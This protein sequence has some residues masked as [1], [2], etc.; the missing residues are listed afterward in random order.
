MVQ[1]DWLPSLL[2]LGSP[3]D[4]SSPS[5]LGVGNGYKAFNINREEREIQSS[6]EV[7]YLVDASEI[8]LPFFI[9]KFIVEVL[10]TLW[11]VLSFSQ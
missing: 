11:H 9:F 2:G 10:T 7:F 5:D 8:F 4:N 3:Q 6:F 1:F